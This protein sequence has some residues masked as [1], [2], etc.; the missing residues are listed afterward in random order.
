MGQGGMGLVW[1]ARHLKLDIDVAI[2]FM[3][4]AFVALPEMRARFEREAKA[5]A[6]L[7]SP[8]VVQV[9]DYGVE[10]DTPYIV[11]EHLEG[12]DLL[13]RVK[14]GAALSPKATARVVVQVCKAL[15]R[16]HEAGLV[17][18]DL[19]PANIFIT[20]HGDE[21]VIKILDFGI[22]KATG[23]V[24]PGLRTNGHML[25]GSPQYMA[26]EQLFDSMGVD[27]RADLYSLAVIAFRCLAG[28][29]P[30]VHKHQAEMLLEI[31]QGSLAPASSLA[32]WMKPGADAFFAKALARDPNARFQSAAELAEAFVTV[33]WSRAEQAKGT[34]AHAGE[35]EEAATLV[36]VPA[37]RSS[38]P[39]LPDGLSP[40]SWTNPPMPAFRVVDVGHVGSVTEPSRTPPP[41]TGILLEPADPAPS[42]RPLVVEARRRGR[43]GAWGL[44][45]ALSAMLTVG[46]GVVTV[47]RRFAPAR[48]AALPPS[49][50]EPVSAAAPSLGADAG[51]PAAPSKEDVP[52]GSTPIAASASA[53]P[54]APT[55]AVSGHAPR[56]PSPK[57]DYLD[58]P[59]DNLGD[60]GA[61]AE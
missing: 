59:Y 53:T 5:A 42:H 51:A 27:H 11:M 1:V 38:E 24:L 36:R 44:G 46:L 34:H 47:T 60:A 7:R 17:H 3:A 18:R 2:K 41:V 16:A 52:P 21:E 43:K 26:P 56:W 61:L 10:E 15:R 54:E 37:P 32:P 58:D 20:Q 31:C 33:D 35:G 14:G 13:S 28:K 39:S 6:L 9:Y 40:L 49:S 57:R 22:V 12:E 48:P 25:M 19:K 29:S 55:P 23:K 4:P 8:N 30:Y 50:G 45:L